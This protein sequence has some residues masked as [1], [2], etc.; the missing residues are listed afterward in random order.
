MMTAL[1]RIIQA[2]MIVLV[3]F[4]N[5]EDSFLN[6]LEAVHNISPISQRGF[7]QTLKGQLTRILGGNSKILKLPS[8]K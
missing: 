8:D 5:E 3:T 1:L 7:L 4:K 6:G 2:L